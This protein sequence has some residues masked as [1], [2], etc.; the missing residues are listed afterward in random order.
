[1]ELLFL[2]I[3]VSLIVVQYALPVKA[4]AIAPNSRS[5]RCC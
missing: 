1:M 5:R 2:F 4:E 3:P